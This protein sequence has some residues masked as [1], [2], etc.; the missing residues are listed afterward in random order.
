MITSVALGGFVFPFDSETITAWARMAFMAV[1][2]QGEN[3][4]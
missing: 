1:I 2:T 4:Y 3:P